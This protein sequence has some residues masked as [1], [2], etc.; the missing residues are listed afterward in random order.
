M[1][2][3]FLKPLK[4]IFVAILLGGLGVSADIAQLTNF[5]LINFF[6]EN[7]PLSY[8]FAFSI[9]IN[10]YLVLV[11]KEII[12]VFKQTST[13]EVNKDDEDNDKKINK[14]KLD[15]NVQFGELKNVGSKSYEIDFKI[16]FVRT[17]YIEIAPYGSNIEYHITNK[18]EYGFTVK[19]RHTEIYKDSNTG[20]KWKAEGQIESQ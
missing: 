14:P 17:P 2:N 7:S 6:K 10:I 19:I 16:P 18:N 13:K 15:D 12:N 9:L 4:Y 20:I 1:L 11:I 3:Y 5:N 8:Y